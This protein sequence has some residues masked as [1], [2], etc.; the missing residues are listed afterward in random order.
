MKTII[1]LILLLLFL[2]PAFAKVTRIEIES[3]EPIANGILFGNSGAYE[4]IS[5]RVYFEVLPFNS[6]NKIIT[7]IHLA[8][9]NANKAVAFSA[10]FYIIK[11]V[12]PA[13][14]NNTLLIEV[15]NRGGKGLLSLFN[16]AA[17][18]RA[19]ITA[20]DMGDGFLLMQGFTI[21]WIGWQYDVPDSSDL[22]RLD[23]PV[24]KKGTSVIT[25]M[26]Y[27]DFLFN[28]KTFSSSLGHLRQKA[29]PAFDTSFTKN[30]LTV[31]EGVLGKKT[32]I[33]RSE[34]FFARQENNKLIPDVNSIYLKSGFEPGRIYDLVY[35]VA[36]PQ[37]VGLGLATVRDFTS[38]LKYDENEIGN[39]KYAIGYG[40]S[41]SGRFLRHFLYEGFNAD[42]KG[43]QVFDGVN[44]HVAG[45]GR[46]SFNHRFAETSWDGKQYYSLFYPADIFPFTDQMQQ[47]PF[48]GKKDGLLTRPQ[49][50]NVLPKIFYTYSSCEYYGR[51]ASL[52][53]TSADGKKDAQIP[54]N[55][56]I[57]YYAGGQ[58]FRGSFIHLQVNDSVP[59]TRNPQTVTEYSWSMKAMLMNLY[60]WISKKT[61]PPASVYP[62]VARNTLVAAERVQFPVFQDAYFPRTYRKIYQL[63]FGPQFTSFGIITNNP[64]VI[65]KAYGVK[66]PQ[67]DKDGIDLDG[68]RMPEVAVPLGTVTGW[69]PRHPL[70]GA[71]EQLTD[72]YGSFFPF[73]KTKS[74][75]LMNKDQRL[76]VEERYADKDAYL[77]E[78]AKYIEKM[79]EK[80]WLLKE[81]KVSEMKYANTVWDRLMK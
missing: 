28:Q 22:L 42:E 49:K 81:D 50:Q 39:Y 18:S 9:L 69:N 12:D 19:P 35:K 31:R 6:F 77:Q 55:V 70:T 74:E 68:I 51:A 37:L 15:S 80:R 61:E 13:K 29:I 5:G 16:H 43:R 75:R 20:P 44:A 47:D 21:V 63:N 65:G 36:N 24:V 67:V 26:T 56:R 7:D 53:H 57:Y 73:A 8:E 32:V 58:H 10:N 30:Q 38:Y 66:L 54:Q 46:G 60:H 45:A 3:R 62:S 59:L 25:G 40:G 48:T 17:G 4:K 27:I 14:G 34:W 33:P 64:P 76:S 71:P 52:T 41:Q 79:I 78:I 1:N 2:V 23:A 72:L 11:P